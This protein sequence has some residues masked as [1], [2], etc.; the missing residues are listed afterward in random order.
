MLADDPQG[1]SPLSEDVGGHLLSFLTNLIWVVWD[2][3]K[4]LTIV[5]VNAVL[6]VNIQIYRY[7]TPFGILCDQDCDLEAIIHEHFV[8]VPSIF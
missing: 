5:I 3:P 7:Q 1:P 8:D 2:A 4:V 6:S